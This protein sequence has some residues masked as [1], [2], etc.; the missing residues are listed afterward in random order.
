MRRRLPP[1]NAL[2]AFEAGAGHL[3]FTRA[4]EELSVTPTAISHQVRQ[5]EEWFGLPL[6]KR[7]SRRLSLTEAGAQLYPVVAEALDRI[8]ESACRIRGQPDRPTLTVSVTPTFG[9][10]WLAARL[11]KF[12]IE[13]PEIDLRVHHSVHLVDFKRDDVDLAVR[14][15]L[16]AWPGT[17]SERLMD[18]VAMPLCSPALLTGPH[19]LREPV[20]LEHHVLL[21]EKDRQ[22]WTEWLIAAGLDDAPG[23]RGPVIDDP[24]SLVRAAIAGHGVFLGSVTMMNAELDSGA[25]VAPFARAGGPEPA[26]F[27]VRPDDASPG[28]AAHAFREFILAETGAGE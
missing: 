12:W 15:G 4:A 19:P 17:V 24:N 16:G 9:S 18:A 25:L 28:R 10:R 5:L 2:R 23:R 8:A 22:E 6:F 14:W 3:N 21:H 1:L 13:H 20:D 11:G 26:Y 27:L 7:G